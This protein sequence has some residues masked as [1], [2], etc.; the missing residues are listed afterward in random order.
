VGQYPLQALD[1][2]V[3]ITREI[4]ASGV[5]ERG[6]R[7]SI[8]HLA[9]DERGG[10]TLREHAVA[11]ATVS[12]SRELKAPALIVITRSGFSARLVSSYRP[13]VPIFA[14]CTD[15]ATFSQLAAVWGVRPLLAQEEE[16]SYEALTEFGKRAVLETGV[17][18]AGESVVVTAG[19]PFHTSG[20]TNT[21]RVEQL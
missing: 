8:D 18:R 16:V 21:M 7:D 12:A 1:A 4:E 20:T 2:I 14:V 10:A 6:S 13:P 3:R 19:Y 9:T 17:G 15:P 11:A 5:L